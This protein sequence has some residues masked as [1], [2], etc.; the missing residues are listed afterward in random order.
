MGIKSSAANRPNN[1]PKSCRCAVG[2]AVT[3]TDTPNPAA[4]DVT[5]S[6]DAHRASTPPPHPSTPARD[7]AKN[8][9]WRVRL[10]YRKSQRASSF[11]PRQSSAPPDYRQT[12]STSTPNPAFASRSRT[13]TS[14]PPNLTNRNHGRGRIRTCTP[15]DPRAA[16]GARRMERTERLDAGRQRTLG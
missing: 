5:D 12:R 13:S 1:H 14:E 2:W 8:Y 7:L 4:K 11:D 16:A 15:D 3:L 10:P 6:S 9:L